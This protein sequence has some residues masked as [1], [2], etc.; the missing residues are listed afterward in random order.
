[1]KLLTSQKDY[2][3][4]LIENKGISP[5]QFEF[6]ERRSEKSPGQ[7]ATILEYKN[8]DF[9][10]SFETHPS[11]KESH[12]SIYCPGVSAYKE[13]KNPG[14]WTLQQ[15]YIEMW[16][17]NL[18]KEI[19]TPDKWSRLNAEIESIKIN[20]D[21]DTT[22][23]SV[24][25]Y[26]DLQARIEILKLKISETGLLEEQISVINNKLDHLT[27][28]A[29][30]LNKFDWKGLFIGTIISIVIQLGVTHENAIVLWDAIKQ[31]FNNILLP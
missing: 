28:L 11:N 26:E 5:S 31:V 23:F 27:E 2:I 16:L 20:F 7:Y 4:D 29:K 19:N 9:F 17:D 30:D 15:D 13:Y 22:K 24:H 12:F 3:Y 6:K 25:E 8:S 21:D 18:V 14:S 1:M 10:F